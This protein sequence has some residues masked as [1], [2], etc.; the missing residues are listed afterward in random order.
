MNYGYDNSDPLWKEDRKEKLAARLRETFPDMRVE[1]DGLY[2]GVR[3]RGL[4][5]E[6]IHPS[7]LEDYDSPEAYIIS[8][9]DR[10]FS[11]VMG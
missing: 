8:V 6:D 11:E 3:L 5:P 7:E 9:A 1:V 2:E 4:I 10:I